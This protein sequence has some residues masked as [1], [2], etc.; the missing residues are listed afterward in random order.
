MP[1][2][3]LESETEGAVAAKAAV[4]GKLL[5]DDG[6]SGRDRL[7]IEFHEVVDAEI[8]DIGI[9]CDTLVGEILA[10]IGAVSAENLC[11]LRKGDVVLQIELGGNTTLI[12]QFLDVGRYGQRLF[13]D[14]NVFKLR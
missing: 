2:A 13:F 9:E 6:L 4:A 10:E 11:K 7:M 5:H 8:V 14:R 1:H 3:L 12:K